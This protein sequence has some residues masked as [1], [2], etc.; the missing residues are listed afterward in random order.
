MSE[1][2]CRFWASRLFRS[3]SCCAATCRCVIQRSPARCEQQDDAER[4]QQSGAS[5]PDPSESRRPRGGRCLWAW[6]WRWRRRAA[7]R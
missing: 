2:S 5:D 7:A 1:G 3:V 6:R 4:D